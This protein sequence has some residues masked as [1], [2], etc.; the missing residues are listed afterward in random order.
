MGE[1]FSMPLDLDRNLSEA[2]EMMALLSTTSCRGEGVKKCWINEM[3]QLNVSAPMEALSHM[4]T[5]RRSRSKLVSASRKDWGFV[6]Y[7]HRHLVKQFSR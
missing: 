2:V 4:T 3:S 5:R 1:V 6:D 7:I